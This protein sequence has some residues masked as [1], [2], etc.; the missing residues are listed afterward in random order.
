MLR[1]GVQY[2]SNISEYSIISIKVNMN[3]IEFPESVYFAKSLLPNSY[4]LRLIK[5]PYG[6]CLRKPS[7]NCQTLNKMYLLSLQPIIVL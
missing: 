2:I 4:K 3:C 5:Y 6:N 1:L 7:I